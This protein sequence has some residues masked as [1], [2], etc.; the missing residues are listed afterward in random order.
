M[1]FSRKQNKEFWR[2]LDPNSHEYSGDSNIVRLEDR[3]LIDELRSIRHG[4][5]LDIGCGKGQRCLMF[6]KIIK[7][8]ILGIDY[9][10]NMIRIAK[11]SES[12]RVKFEHTD[13]FSFDS[14]KRFDIITS[15]RC[16]INTP[17][18][19]GQMAIIKKI[20]SL[21]KPS[22]HLILVERS[23]QGL[24]SLNGLRKKIGLDP[25][26]ERFHN[27]Y[28]NESLL[29]P[30]VLENFNLIK[31]SRLGMLYVVSRVI[32]PKMIHPLRPKEKHVINNIGIE[33]QKITNELDSYGMQFM[34]H[35]QKKSKIKSTKK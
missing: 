30:K 15:C 22:G 10:E 8:N 12:T 13:I 3:F 2:S 7:G 24:D 34:I 14:R 1:K 17:T 20:E 16:I 5:L 18:D 4:D 33:L 35:L 11:K 29:M 6:S 19:Q 23:R 21:L 31:I 28:I 26:P 32:Y 25:I 9:S 27:H